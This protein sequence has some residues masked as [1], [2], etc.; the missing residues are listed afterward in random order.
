[1]DTFVRQKGDRSKPRHPSHPWNKR[2]QYKSSSPSTTLLWQLFGQHVSLP[3]VQILEPIVKKEFSTSYLNLFEPMKVLNDS[4]LIHNDQGIIQNHQSYGSVHITSSIHSPCSIII[5]CYDARK[6]VLIIC[7]FAFSGKTDFWSFL[8]DS[9]SPM[10]YMD[11][12]FY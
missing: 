4:K 9:I 11:S 12:P 1:M 6:H 8:Q 5:V 2:Q 7:I 3:K 10:Y